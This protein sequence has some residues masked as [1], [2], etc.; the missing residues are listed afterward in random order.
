MSE[1]FA[2]YDTL[3]GDLTF[4]STFE[5]AEKEYADAKEQ[6][7]EDV[8]TGDEQVY[9]FTV[10]KV[11]N[12]VKDEDKQNEARERGLDFIVKWQDSE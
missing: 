2:V 10:K 6:L 12:L 9:I 11:A 1:N 4:H 5:Q 8:V 7:I 3:T